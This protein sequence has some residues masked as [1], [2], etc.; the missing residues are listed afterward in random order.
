M[1]PAR[2][3][4]GDLFPTETPQKM[5]E[6][7]GIQPGESVLDI[8]GGHSPLPEATVVVE[9]NLA[10]A[11]D[12]DGHSIPMDSRYVEGDAQDLPFSDKAF[13]F[14]YASHVFE[15]VRDPGK[16]CLEMIR[17]ARRGYIETPRKMT[18]LF[19]GYPS[20]RWLVDV[21][22]GVLTFERRWFI[23]SPYRNSI[24]AHV[25]KFEGARQQALVNFRNLTCVQF[26]W[27]VTFPF[28]VKERS[29]WQTEFDYD[30]P[31]HAAWSH[32][33]FAVNLLA[34]GDCWEN[35]HVHL[36]TALA[37]QPREGIFYVLQGVGNLLLDS[38]D[39]ARKSF[40]NA[41]SL[42]CSDPAIVF[43]LEAIQ[44]DT[45]SFML[46]L[47]RGLVSRRTVGLIAESS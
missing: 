46:P 21:D 40:E 11:H 35:T 31:I 12:R 23:E 5:A 2:N 30:N 16:A 44:R 9:Y 13:E 43:N 25:H 19:A 26:P 37:I 1:K 18:E 33:Y 10:S 15:H 45:D 28:R 42:H 27:Q 41:K 17:V 7:L 47:D 32:F 38:S 29:G 6:A 24:L 14:A 3:V 4:V 22:D 8:G 34:N 39:A 20:H 36:Q